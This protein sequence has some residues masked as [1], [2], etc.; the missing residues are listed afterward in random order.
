MKEPTIPRQEILQA[1]C[2]QFSITE[3]ELVSPCRKRRLVLA[4]MAYSV[5]R[6]RDKVTLQRIGA[7]LGR[8]HATIVRL[9]KE[10]NNDYRYFPP[11]TADYDGT[12][13][14]LAEKNYIICEKK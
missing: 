2:G 6:R 4:R 1:V 3:E 8:E 5:L 10:H 11:Y 12:L 14:R 9:L 7:E 13:E